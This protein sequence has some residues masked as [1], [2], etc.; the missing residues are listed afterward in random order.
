MPRSDHYFATQP[1]VP[2]SPHTVRV[3]LRDLHL[4]LESD[5]GVFAAAR[6]D[7][8]TRE[9]LE[10]APHP[11]PS[12]DLLD[13][14]T[15]YG[16]IAIALARRSPEARVW[17][18]DVNERALELVRRNLV[19]AGTGNVVPTSPD[20][21]PAQTRFAAIYSNPPIR[22]GKEAL[23]GMLEHWL[24]RLAP[25]AR[26]FLVVQRHL[27]S[28]SLARWLAESGHPTRRLASRKGYRILEV[29]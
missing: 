14:G 21:V 10:V 8:G 29:S 4:E 1:D 18:V 25:G 15:G 6:L 7:P 23:H 3:D 2:S 22:I 17:A 19:T 27:G 9:L 20:Q 28:D 26:C 5:R 16:P 13:L 12:G 11:P 24:E